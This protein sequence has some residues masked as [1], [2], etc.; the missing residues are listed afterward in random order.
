MNRLT[1]E[2]RNVL[3]IATA[4]FPK[5]LDSAVLSRADHIEEI[6]LPDEVACREII[7][8]TLKAMGGFGS[9]NTANVG[10]RNLARDADFVS[11]PIRVD[12]QLDQ[13]IYQAFPPQ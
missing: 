7:A 3:L 10:M 12:A 4:N 11:K 1:R 8:D 5:A 6:G 2:H 13:L 9:V